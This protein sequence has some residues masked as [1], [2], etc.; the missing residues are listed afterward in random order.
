MCNFF[1]NSLSLTFAWTAFFKIEQEY[2]E[3]LHLEMGLLEGQ[4]VRWYDR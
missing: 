4:L 1:K 3:K 2:P